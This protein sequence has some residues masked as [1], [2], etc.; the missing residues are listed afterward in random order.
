MN[1]SNGYLQFILFISERYVSKAWWLLNSTTWQRY[2]DTRKLEEVIKK[3]EIRGRPV[4]N[5]AYSICLSH[6]CW[7]SLFISLQTRQISPT[8]HG[9]CSNKHKQLQLEFITTLHHGSWRNV[10]S[11]ASSS[12]NGNLHRMDI[13]HVRILIFSREYTSQQTLP[14]DPLS[15]II[16]PVR[17]ER[18]SL[19]SFHELVP[20]FYKNI[21]CKYLFVYLLN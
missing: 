5:Y 11:S 14:Q 16:G 3:N 12:R 4:C 6:A 10:D 15:A 21:D 2:T 1:C 18:H 9:G 7:I 19:I 17:P 8:E 13:W 20:E